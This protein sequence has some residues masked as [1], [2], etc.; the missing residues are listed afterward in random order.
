[1]FSGSQKS[2]YTHTR[3]RIKQQGYID[4]TTWLY[5]QPLYA[6]RAHRTTPM[7]N[8]SYRTFWQYNTPLEIC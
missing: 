5:M 2:E 3:W 6:A 1:M 8:S 7:D 4:K